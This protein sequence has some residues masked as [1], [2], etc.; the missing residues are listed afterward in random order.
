MQPAGHRPRRQVASAMKTGEGDLTLARIR[1]RSEEAPRSTQ[2]SGNNSGGL[3]VVTSKLRPYVSAIG[4]CCLHQSRPLLHRPGQGELGDANLRPVRGVV[5]RLRWT[6]TMVRRTG[7]ERTK[8]T[9]RCVRRRS[10]QWPTKCRE[11]PPELGL[12]S[13]ARSAKLTVERPGCP[14]GPREGGAR[15]PR[16]RHC[17]RGRNPHVSLAARLRRRGE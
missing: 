4:S 3:P 1:G 16:P 9:R 14:R 2:N 8:A 6:L 17:N 13:H 11:A 5:N 12:P 15:P 10:S 7:D